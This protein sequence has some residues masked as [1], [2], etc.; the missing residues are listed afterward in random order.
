MKLF[1][2]S[3]R[4]LKRSF[5]VICCYCGYIHIHQNLDLPRK[6]CEKCRAA[7]SIDTSWDPHAVRIY[8]EHADPKLIEDFI[9]ELKSKRVRLRERKSTTKSKFTVSK[10]SKRVA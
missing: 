3:S 8:T 4:N 6:A 1:L 9:A 5:K 2:G 10:K 7:L